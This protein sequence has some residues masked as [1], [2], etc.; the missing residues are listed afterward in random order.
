MYED[1]YSGSPF[2][3]H[4][5]QNGTQSAQ[6]QQE[7]I[8]Q[9]GETRRESAHQYGTYDYQYANQNGAGSSASTGANKNARKKSSFGK[10]LAVIL[11]VAIAA[12][13]LC[14]AGV[15]GLSK[16][17]ETK[18]SRSADGKSWSFSWS[19]G[20][21]FGD[22]FTQEEDKSL[23]QQAEDS[24]AAA[25]DEADESRLTLTQ[26]SGKDQEPEQKTA[27]EINQATAVVTDVTEVAENVMPSV[28]SVFNNYTAKTRD[29]WGQTYYQ[30]AQSTGSG[31]IIAENDDGSELL[32]ATNNHVVEGED[33]LQVQFIDNETVDAQI[34]GTDPEND[35]AVIVVNT[36]DLK[37]ETKAAIKVAT[38]GVSDELKIGEP[39]IAIGNAL[40]YG[41]SVTTGVIS[42]LNREIMTEDGST[43]GT[44]IQTDAAINFGNSGGALCNI[45]GEVIGINSNK[46][47]GNAVEGMGY[48]IPIDRAVP[49]I[50][51]LM[52][53]ETRERYS[54]EEQGYL[55]INGVSVT[56]QVAAAYHMPEGAYIAEIVDGSAAAKSDLVKG[57]IITKVDDT[58]VGSMEDLKEQLSY[59]AAGDKITLTIQRMNEKGDYEEET[60][61]I[62][63]GSKDTLG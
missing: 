45:A 33:S 55:G 40:G 28:V 24:K 44:L 29:W 12:G 15:Y 6:T 41:Q 52:N 31:I 36:A 22:L 59:Y 46:I 42:A 25:A 8:S 27:I 14:G 9:Y 19:L 50:E 26:S 5:A 23:T 3:E 1:N 20:D 48:A 2:E 10:T 11:A 51:D 56:E 21:D 30:D 63:L 53:R 13:G 35:L 60:I 18:V 43:S 16:Y 49:I 32:I 34:K 57:D 54:A 61:E 47:G 37:D 4:N 62:T 17:A 7:T 38:L 39:A 58:E